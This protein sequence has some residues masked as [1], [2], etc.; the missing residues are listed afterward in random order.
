MKLLI[1]ATV[2]AVLGFLSVCLL[3]FV[4]QRSILFRPDVTRVPPASVGLGQAQEVML[5]PPAGNRLIGW[6]IPP[7]NESKIVALYLHGN[8]AN[9]ARRANR[10]DALSQDGSGVLAISWRGYGGSEGSPSEAGF[11]EDARAALAFLKQRAIPLE[12]TVLFGESLGTGVAVAL[13]ADT[14]VKAMILDSPYD[15][16]QAL[17]QKRYWWLPVGLLLRDPFRADLSASSV[18]MPVLAVHCERDPITPLENADKLMALL[19]GTHVRL[20][21]PAACHAPSFPQLA[22][23]SGWSGAGLQGLL[24]IL[25]QRGPKP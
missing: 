12:R 9:I 14:P 13:A 3:M 17:A 8:G 18:K 6:F 21:V 4:F 16:I 11:M 22:A 10:L 25:E 19:G 5:N 23:F 15:S 24:A 7:A 1:R 2:L 20:T